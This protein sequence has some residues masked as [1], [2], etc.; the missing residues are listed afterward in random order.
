MLRL[1]PDRPKARDL[2]AAPA[3]AVEGSS[4]KPGNAAQLRGIRIEA[5][6][7]PSVFIEKHP[8]RWKGL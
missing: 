3:G 8:A 2:D 5:V 4:T 6:E 7:S 1:R